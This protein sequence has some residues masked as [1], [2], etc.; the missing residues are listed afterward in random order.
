M[1]TSWSDRA[2][3]KSSLGDEILVLMN[4]TGKIP[5]DLTG[6]RPH[7]QRADNSFIPA[8]PSMMSSPVTPLGSS[9]GLQ[10]TQ[11]RCQQLDEPSGEPEYPEL[12]VGLGNYSENRARAEPRAELQPIPVTH[13]DVRGQHGEGFEPGHL[14]KQTVHFSH[15]S[16]GFLIRAPHLGVLSHGGSSLVSQ[17]SEEWVP[18]AH[19]AHLPH[20][21]WV[22]FWTY[23]PVHQER[24]KCSVYREYCPSGINGHGPAVTAVCSLGC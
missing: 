10:H 17:G 16:T 2:R 21:H 13:A 20:S 24:W 9:V 4:Q 12:A 15:P 5:T 7:C 3:E 6:V 1:P 11:G 19:L 23:W 14:S 8:P 22:L 18:A